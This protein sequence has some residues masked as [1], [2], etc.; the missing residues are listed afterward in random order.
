MQLAHGKARGFRAVHNPVRPA[1]VTQF[2]IEAVRR[3]AV[4]TGRSKRRTGN[5]HARPGDLAVG[6]G[7][8]QRDHD[9]G[10]GANVA[11]GCEAG[12]QRVF[13]AR[14]GIE[15]VIVTRSRHGFGD[16]IAAVEKRGDVIVAI[17]Q[18]GQHRGI[19]KVDD[20]GA[21]RR[22][23]ALLHLCD[24]VVVDQDGDLR[25][26]GLRHTVDQPPG[27][28]DDVLCLSLPRREHQNRRKRDRRKSHL[29][30]RTLNTPEPID[31]L[32]TH[33]PAEPCRA[34]SPCTHIPG[35]SPR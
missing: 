29:T 12:K 33:S 35:P 31:D 19:G 10:I 22:D 4:T 11:D 5:E 34:S 26:F 14:D 9:I 6:D 20:F 30:P 17:D 21:R 15:R 28:N 7:L 25:P 2:R 8:L 24:A 32:P 1:F 3:I 27:M 23:E 16:G 18:S 13:G